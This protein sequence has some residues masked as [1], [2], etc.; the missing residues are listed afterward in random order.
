M[1]CGCK[2][3]EKAI[4]VPKVVQTPQ[5]LQVMRQEAL[6]KLRLLAMGIKG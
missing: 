3:N 4:Q 5:Q 1:S 2:K 6:R